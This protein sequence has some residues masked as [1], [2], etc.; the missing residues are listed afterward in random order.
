MMNILILVKVHI[1]YTH[2]FSYFNDQRDTVHIEY[3]GQNYVQLYRKN[4]LNL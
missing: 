3:E 1:S 2:F 4:I